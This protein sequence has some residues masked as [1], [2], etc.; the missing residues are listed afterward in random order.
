MM[1]KFTKETEF[2]SLRVHPQDFHQ[3]LRHFQEANDSG[4][5]IAF[6]P[7]ILTMLSRDLNP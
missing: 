1:S 7:F 2:I 4:N 6:E 3:S 5:R